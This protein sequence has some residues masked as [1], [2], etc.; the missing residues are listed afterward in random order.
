MRSARGKSQVK[1]PQISAEE[2]A[3]L[4]RETHWDQRELKALHAIYMRYSVGAAPVPVERLR[5][6]PET[7]TIPLMHRVLT[8]HNQD[9]SGL[10]TF[11]EFARAM[12]ALSPK[13]TLD[14]KLRFAYACFDMN[15][16]GVVDTPEVFQLLRMMHGRTS[17]DD[18]LQ[19]VVDR[20]MANHPEGL[21][22][23]SFRDLLDPSDLSKLTLS[24]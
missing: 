10:I 12:S 5:D 11:A 23:E 20:V 13:A 14:E 24:V 22:Y 18:A 7:A 4:E 15:A 6:I 1:Q 3:A 17:N 21:T 19:A 16:N 9:R 8:I 2:S